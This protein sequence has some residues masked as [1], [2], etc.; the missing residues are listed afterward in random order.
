MLPEATAVVFGTQAKVLGAD[1][2][3][4]A[5]AEAALEEAL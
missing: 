1:V 3:D 5:R 2:E 4:L